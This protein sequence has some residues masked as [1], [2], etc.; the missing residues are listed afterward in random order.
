MFTR[1]SAYAAIGAVILIAAGIGVSSPSVTAVADQQ[2]VCRSNATGILRIP[3]PGQPCISKPA[4]LAETAV[5]LSGPAG[6]QGQPGPPGPQGD[7][8]P[9]GPQGE[10]GPA[11]PQGEAGIQGIPGPQG[12]PGEP[13][14]SISELNGVACTGGTIEVV[15]G[16]EQLNG[17]RPVDL[18]CRPAQLNGILGV[19]LFRGSGGFLGEPA[20]SPTV[21]LTSNA[22]QRTCAL[23][24]NVDQTTCTFGFPVGTAL[25]IT[26]VNLQSVTS[27]API[28]C[29]GIGPS[30]QCQYTVTPSG[31]ITVGGRNFF[32]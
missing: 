4:A 31:S 26:G 8:G 18:Q 10:V 30:L 22:V 17:I 27:F 19:H 32:S 23:P 16:T 20:P 5:V 11:G 13:I 9:T 24:S 7:I 21:T 15:Y 2:V 3:A 25:T 14:A 6:V 29:T 12:E 1:K 28:T